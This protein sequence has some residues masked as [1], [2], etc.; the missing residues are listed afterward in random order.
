MSKFCINIIKGLLRNPEIRE[1][2]NKWAES[3]INGTLH[4]SL[5][6]SYLHSN[7]PEIKELNSENVSM[8]VEC[9]NKDVIFYY[10]NGDWVSEE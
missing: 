5:V 1:G 6:V 8:V 10:R 2:L 4:S 3:V 9:G 7:I